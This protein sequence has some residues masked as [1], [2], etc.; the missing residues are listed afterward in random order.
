MTDTPTPAI[1]APSSEVQPTPGHIFHRMSLPVL[2]FCAV[3]AMALSISRMAILPALTAVE[4]GG[5]VRDAAGLQAHAHELETK[6]IVL[7][8]NRDT[9]ILPMDG[10]PY[11]AL[12]DAKIGNPSVGELLEA[13]RAVAKTIVPD[14]PEAVMISGAAYDMDSSTLTL[15]GDVRR[16]GPGSMTVLAAFTENLRED[17][18][19]TSLVAP[20][21][22][23]L[24][25]PKIGPHSPFSIVLTLR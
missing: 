13:F 3:L 16:V 12:V 8:E 14:M 19:V 20:A 17:P 1:A 23:R 4:V 10:T 9:E 25:D 11:R 15:K 22:S 21:F 5:V 2:L 18:R 24:E 6:L 7:Q